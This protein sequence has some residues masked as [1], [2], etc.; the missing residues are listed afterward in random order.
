MNASREQPTPPRPPVSIK[1]R[2]RD[3]RVVL[4]D[5]GDPAAAERSLRDQ[6][7]RRAGAFFT[8]A[9]VT[10]E[11]PGA[12]IDFDL[13]GRLAAAI[14]DAGMHVSAVSAGGAT[15]AAPTGARKMDEPTAAP[16][17]SETGGLMAALIVE[18]TLRGGQRLEHAGDVIVIG[19]VNPGAELVAGGSVI[20]WGRLRGTVEAG[21]GRRGAV[22]C[23][24]DLAPSQLVIGT[25]I[26][27]APD[28]PSRHPAPEI[29][30]EVDGRIE[31]EDWR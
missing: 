21:G 31:V 26:A 17:D 16:P 2:G 23:A 12:A 9:P 3:L 20:V 28:D 30:R 10:L 18:R 5:G 27:R 7:Q 29:A 1:G 15:A 22:V 6:L 4:E 24:L 14:S 19:D 8:G 11:M 13:A 25:A